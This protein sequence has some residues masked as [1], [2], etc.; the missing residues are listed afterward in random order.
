[1]LRDAYNLKLALA[2]FCFAGMIGFTLS[3]GFSGATRAHEP[4]CKE[5]AIALAQA[6][7]CCKACEAARDGITQSR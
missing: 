5:L 3:G 7:A 6:K 4:D 1:M 2:A